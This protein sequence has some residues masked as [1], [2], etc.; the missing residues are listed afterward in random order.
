M[1]KQ[2]YKTTHEI[3]CDSVSFAVMRVDGLGFFTHQDWVEEN[4]PTWT[5][6]KNGR[7]FLMGTLKPQAKLLLYR[8]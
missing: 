3:T 5:V 1:T 7:L 6:S 4:G 8:H 2:A